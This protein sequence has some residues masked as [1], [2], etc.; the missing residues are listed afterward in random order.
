MLVLTACSAGELPP[1][2]APP[3]GRRPLAVPPGAGDYAFGRFPTPLPLP[4]AQAI[5]RQ[6]EV[7]SFGGMPP[8]RQVQAFNVVM[9]QPDATARFQALA[10]GASPVGRLYALA[11]LLMLDPTA[12][13]HLKRQLLADG[14]DV[15][16]NA[17]DTWDL[18]SVRQLAEM[19]EARE[20]G[21]AFTQARDETNEW[22]AGRK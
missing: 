17:S 11:G 10:N 19:V 5:L 6:T 13:D 1:P 4:D 22:Y 18:Q 8:K 7:F 14:R 21:V 12:A 20:M 9:E 3:D 16:V 2:P 15:Q